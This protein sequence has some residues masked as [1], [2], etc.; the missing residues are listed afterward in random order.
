LSAIFVGFKIEKSN[1]FGIA[2]NSTRSM[3]VFANIISID[4]I[5]NKNSYLLNHP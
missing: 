1:T 4:V 2:K 5:R 3:I